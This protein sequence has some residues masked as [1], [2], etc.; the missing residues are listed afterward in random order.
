MP[1]K[2]CEDER[3][4]G[5]PGLV[6]ESRGQRLDLASRS[7]DQQIDACLAEG[8]RRSAVSGSVCQPRHSNWPMLRRPW[9]G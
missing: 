1:A 2:G 5:D 8:D 7:L 4:M 6:I 9:G 3:A